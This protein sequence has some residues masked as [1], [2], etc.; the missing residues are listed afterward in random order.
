MTI[1]VGVKTHFR[2]DIKVTIQETKLLRE[3][4]TTDHRMHSSDGR[5]NQHAA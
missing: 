2:I 4:K 3:M 1:L 5:E